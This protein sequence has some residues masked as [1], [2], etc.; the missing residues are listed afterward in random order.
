M[1]QLTYV[2]TWFKSLCEFRNGRSRY[3]RFSG[4]ISTLSEITTLHY[5][6]K[7]KKNKQKGKTVSLNEFLSA[8]GSTPPMP[9]RTTSWADESNELEDKGKYMYCLLK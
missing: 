7:K 8:D 2:S 4:D 6:G 3:A 1:T 5:V 9:M